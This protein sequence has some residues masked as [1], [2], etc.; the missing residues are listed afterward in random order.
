[1]KVLFLTGIGISFGEIYAA[2]HAA[3]QLR[4]TGHNVEFACAC[5]EPALI[6]RIAGAGFDVVGDLG[7]PP[8]LSALIGTDVDGPADFKERLH[9]LISGAHDIIYLIDYHHFFM[10]PETLP[11]FTPYFTMLQEALAQTSKRIWTNDHSLWALDPHPSPEFGRRIMAPPASVEN[12]FLPAPP[13]FHRYDGCRENHRAAFFYQ[14]LLN[15][16]P[17]KKSACK[18]LNLILSVS[19]FAIPIADRAPLIAVDT[20]LT[21][22]LKGLG[23]LNQNIRLT[24]TGIEPER[25][26][27]LTLPTNVTLDESMAMNAAGFDDYDKELTT[28]DGIILYNAISVTITRA[29]FMQI[30]VVLLTHSPSQAHQD[31]TMP[32]NV[33]PAYVPTIDLVYKDNPCFHHCTRCELVDDAAL[34]EAMHGT[35]AGTAVP[36][37]KELREHFQD[38]PSLA[39]FC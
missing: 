9:K 23:A 6:D 39:D 14:D 3:R 1:M 18:S 26:H 15:N 36:L 19:H 13:H 10:R 7:L 29:L 31:G 16:A 24:V 30:P 21:Q 2:M 28:Y 38:L 35:L 25:L 33:Y 12:I 8:M 17:K 32:Y 27:A 11:P 4:A 34:A 37:T 5:H 20:I 22:A